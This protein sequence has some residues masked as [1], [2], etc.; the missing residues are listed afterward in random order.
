MGRV[1]AA[2]Q[3]RMANMASPQE[4]HRPSLDPDTKSF[5]RTPCRTAWMACTRRCW[6]AT[7][8]PRRWRRP[9]R[10]RRLTSPMVSRSAALMRCALHCVPTHPRCVCGCVCEGVGWGEDGA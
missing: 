9:S 3:G 6:A 7:S 1:G 5:S 4:E 8:M 10:A 2:L